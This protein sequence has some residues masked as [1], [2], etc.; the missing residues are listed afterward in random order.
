LIA[1]VSL[2]VHVGLL[3]AWMNGQPQLRLA[4]P[5]ILQVELIRPSAPM[6]SRPPPRLAASAPE[7]RPPASPAAP[8]A[9]PPP[10]PRVAS[11]PNSID[12]RLLTDQELLARSG[13][14]PDIA[15]LNAEEARQPLFSRPLGRNP[16]DGWIGGCKPSWATSNRTAPPCRSDSAEEQAARWKAANDGKTEGFEAEG[17]Y[18]RA[19]KT[20][21]EAPGGAGYPGIKCAM[22]HRC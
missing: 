21:H 17:A 19:M 4:E 7:A 3:A 9:S 14:R 15:R 16:E 2:A 13:P 10:P 18:K 5:A 22:L 20:Y 6:R 12:P 8:P 11:A 1:A